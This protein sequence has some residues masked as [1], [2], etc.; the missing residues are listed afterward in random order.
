MKI[1]IACEFSGVVWKAFT[2]LGHDVL[3]CDLL[4]S[5][6]STNH[7]QGDV[8]D[9]LTEKWDMM[10]GHPDCTYMCNSGV[11][12]YHTEP[13]RKEKTQLASDFFYKLWNADIPK[14]CLENPIPHKYANLPKYS[15]KIQPWMFGHGETKATC[16]WLKNLSPLRPTNIVDGRLQKIHLM[17]PSKNR[18]KERSRSYVGIGEAMANQWGKDV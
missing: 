8:L 12:W 7:Y 10:I 18:S 9:I 14:I 6:L 5:E 1:L 4:S 11:R 3:G 15:Q 17:G 13:G 16:L 2:D